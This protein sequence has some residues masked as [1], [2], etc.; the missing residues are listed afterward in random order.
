MFFDLH[1][2]EHGGTDIFKG[3]LN[4]SDLHKYYK[5]SDTFLSEVLQIWSEISFNDNITSNKQFRSMNLWHN[6][7]IKVGNS[8]IYYITCATK[9]VREVRQLMK[10]E[11]NFFLS[12][13]EFRERFNIKRNYLTFHGIVAAIKPQRKFLRGNDIPSD[14][15]EDDTFVVKFFQASKPNKLVYKKL[16]SLKQTSPSKSQNKWIVDCNLEFRVDKLECGL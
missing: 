11:N 15:N 14:T 7:L 4:K 6:S 2:T 10:D 13:A 9:G 5:I 8:P 12:L 1:L 16:I 3:N